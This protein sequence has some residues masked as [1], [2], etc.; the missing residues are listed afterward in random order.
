MSSSPPDTPSQ[1]FS[2]FT[3]SRSLFAESPLIATRAPHPNR[4]DLTLDQLSMAETTPLKPSRP[5]K[6]RLFGEDSPDGALDDLPDEGPVSWSE[7]GDETRANDQSAMVGNDTQNEEAEEEDMGSPVSTPTKSPEVTAA[8]RR[9]AQEDELRVA[10]FQ[11]RR[12]NGV[13]VAHLDA[14]YATETNHKVSHV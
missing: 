8:M 4:D 2:L 1:S 11:M 10:L 5:S 6:I 7:A 13:L 3:K 14:L 12:I 9:Q